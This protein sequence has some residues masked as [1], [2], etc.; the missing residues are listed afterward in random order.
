MAAMALGLFA[1]V[2]LI[3]SV[4]CLCYQR[5]VLGFV[6]SFVTMILT[7]LARS[8]WRDLLIGSGKDPSL[9]GFHRYPAAPV[10]LSALLLTAFIVMTVSI[11]WIVRRNKSKNMQ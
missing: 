1:A 9:L 2:L 10:I 7:Y 4:C 6:S 11:F 5:P 8:R 3:S